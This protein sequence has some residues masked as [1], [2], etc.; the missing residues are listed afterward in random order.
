[1]VEV[2]GADH[3]DRALVHGPHLMDAVVALADSVDD[4][5]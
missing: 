5:R 1:V 2:P 3:N 4:P